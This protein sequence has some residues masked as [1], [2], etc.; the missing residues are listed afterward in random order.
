MAAKSNNESG[1]EDFW[2]QLQA[3]VRMYPPR[4]PRVFRDHSDPL[5]EYTDEEFRMRIRL[6]KRSVIELLNRVGVDLEH[7]SNRLGV[8][9]P[10]HQL[11]IAL[12]FYASGSFQVCRW[13][14]I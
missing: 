1:E 14:I 4:R 11:L 10:V 9:A 5:N 12:R 3:Y 8:L 6:D 7:T 2:G 13:M